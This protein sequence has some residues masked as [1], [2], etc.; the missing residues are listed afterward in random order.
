MR[1]DEHVARAARV[2]ADDERAAAPDQ[3]VGGRPAQ[4][5][6]ERGLE[7]DV[8]DAADAVRA[9]EAG[10]GY[11]SPDGDRAASRVGGRSGVA[12]GRGAVRWRG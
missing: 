11:G 2:L 8:R 5:V 6:G 4:G 3:P 10:H 1:G 7:I 9:E 12:L